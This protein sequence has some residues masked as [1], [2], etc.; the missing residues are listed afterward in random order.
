MKLRTAQSLSSGVRWHHVSSVKDERERSSLKVDS[1]CTFRVH[2]KVKYCT[3]ILLYVCRN[4]TSCD[5]RRV[6]RS[7]E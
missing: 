1:L 2:F 3:T 7:H 6:P 5:G 4:R